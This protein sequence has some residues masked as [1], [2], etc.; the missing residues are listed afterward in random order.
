MDFIM[1]GPWV[2]CS[3]NG[4]DHGRRPG[5]AMDATDGFGTASKGNTVI[6]RGVRHVQNS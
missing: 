2:L 4:L 3:Q 1:V 5:W 6:F